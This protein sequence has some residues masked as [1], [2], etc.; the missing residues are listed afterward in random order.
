M[1]AFL[2][3]FVFCF[4]FSGY[5]PDGPTEAVEALQRLQDLGL[6][7]AAVPALD[8]VVDEEEVDHGRH[9]DEESGAVAPVRESC[10]AESAATLRE[11]QRKS[12]VPVVEIFGHQ[13]VGLSIGAV[14]HGVD[15][16]GVVEQRQDGVKDDLD[17]LRAPLQRLA[18][19]L[20]ESLDGVPQLPLK[21]KHPKAKPDSERAKANAIQSRQ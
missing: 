4:F 12:D 16:V 17:Q 14:P 20:E 11:R 10:G 6:D 1:K 8:L 5:L 21:K 13:T 15:K 9:D 7:P 18:G 2:F 19:R 3:L